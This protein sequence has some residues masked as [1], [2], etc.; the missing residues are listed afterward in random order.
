MTK[1]QAVLAGVSGRVAGVALAAALFAALVLAPVDARQGDVYRLLFVHVP[2]AWLAY[3]AFFVTFVGSV[4]Y[5]LRGNPA[6]DRVAASS[7][8]VG[9]LFTGLAI[10]TGAIWGRATWGVWWDW[11]PRLTTTAVLF[12]VFL[13]YVLLRAGIA[14]EARR[15]RVSA[16]LGVVGF[17]NVPIVHFSVL[18]WR[19]LH[20]PPTVI[21]PGDPTIDHGMLAVLALSVLAFTALYVYLVRERLTLEATAARSQEH[22]AAIG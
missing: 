12:L 1:V 6:A 5:L 20:Q 17:A 21:R 2:S 4:A 9:V 3:L 15:A 7:A 22:L 14:G 13:A 16:A 10:A 8:E 11:D 18:L 19:S